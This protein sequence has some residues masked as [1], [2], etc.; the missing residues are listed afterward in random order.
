MSLPA[1]T[2]PLKITPTQA[3]GAKP[4]AAKQ[5]DKSKEDKD[6][7]FFDLLDIINPLQH[8]PVVSTIY[9]QITG[10]KIGNFARVAGGA[11]YG[12]FAG[13][14][15]GGVNA[16]AA[17]ETGHDIG[18]LAM[19]K[20]GITPR[21]AE[22]TQLADAAPSDKDKD[23]EVAKTLA[24]FDADKRKIPAA[25]SHAPVP[26]PASGGSGNGTHDIPVI[27]VRPQQQATA[28]PIE[29][30]KPT[31]APVSVPVQQAAAAAKHFDP[32]FNAAPARQFKPL[33][34]MGDTSALTHAMK[35]LAMPVRKTLSPDVATYKSN[36]AGPVGE[37]PGFAV[38]APAQIPAA[39]T[40]ALA[41]YQAMQTLGD[42]TE[43]TDENPRRKFASN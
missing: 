43:S 12:G 21:D 11:L 18:E 25:S 32:L 17:Q 2:A 40:Q 27:E 33:Q 6:F 7:S 41:K 10:D 8:I 35:P 37:M 26:T 14:I 13:A 24:A 19:Q 15:V 29:L 31:E 9:R 5:A 3:A 39:M 1:A 23:A 16:I 34:R 38:P 30:P 28:A 20:M 22:K 36:V 42:N 4:Q